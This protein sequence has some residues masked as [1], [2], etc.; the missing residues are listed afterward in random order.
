MIQIVSR[1]VLLRTTVTQI[2]IQA[3]QNKWLRKEFSNSLFFW[4]TCS[5]AREWTRHRLKLRWMHSSVKCRMLSQSSWKTAEIILLIILNKMDL[6]M[7]RVTQPRWLIHLRSQAQEE[8]SAATGWCT[9]CKTSHITSSTT[10][11]KRNR[12][13]PKAEDRHPRALLDSTSHRSD[14][15]VVELL[16]STIKCYQRISKASLSALQICLSRAVW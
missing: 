4:W 12:L 11:V 7:C 14:T 3:A 10:S 1:Q 8:Y 6:N 16:S 9:P 2:Q 13:E 15:K 5:W